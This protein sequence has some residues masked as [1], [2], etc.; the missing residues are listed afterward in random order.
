M[1]P[2]ENAF[3]KKIK[4]SDSLNVSVNFTKNQLDKNK[5]KD[6]WGCHQRGWLGPRKGGARWRITLMFRYLDMIL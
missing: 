6:T 3:K 2:Q 5:Q 4:Q 1:E